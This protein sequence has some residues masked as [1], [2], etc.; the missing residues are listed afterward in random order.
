MRLSKVSAPPPLAAIL[1]R[2]GAGGGRAVA[3]SSKTCSAG[4]AHARLSWGEKCLKAGQY[5]T[6][7]GDR[8]YHRYYFHCH[9][10][11]LSRSAAG[12]NSIDS[13]MSL[14]LRSATRGRHG[15]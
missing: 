7:K 13:G 10:G 12:G 1:P 9:T 15:E 2:A 6:I 8:E 3:G 4:S 11:R 14:Q 5:C